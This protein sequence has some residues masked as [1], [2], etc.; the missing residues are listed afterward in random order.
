MVTGSVA[1][2]IASFSGVFVLEPDGSASGGLTMHD[3]TLLGKQDSGFYSGAIRHT[4][5]L[6][7]DGKKTVMYDEPSRWIRSPKR[8]PTRRL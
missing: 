4:R 1:D 6:L 7:E 5:E 2:K 3:I 8:T